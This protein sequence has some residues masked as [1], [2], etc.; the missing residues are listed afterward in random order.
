MAR[1]RTARLLFRSEPQRT[2]S[3]SRRDRSIRV[4]SAPTT[5]CGAGDEA[6]KVSWVTK[7]ASTISFRCWSTPSVGQPSPQA[8]STPVG[9]GR[10][11][12]CGAGRE[13]C[14]SARRRFRD[15]SRH[16][17][18]SRYGNKLDVGGNRTR[19]QLRDSHK[20]HAV[21]LGHERR[22]AA[23]TAP[24]TVG[25][26]LRRPVP[27][28]TGRPLLPEQRVGH[29]CA[30]HRWHA[31]VLWRQHRRPS[32]RRDLRR[33]AHARAGRNADSLAVC[34]CRGRTHARHF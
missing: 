23:G 25:P 3:R 30:S 8:L 21:V 17:R 12:R 27:R 24:P 6:S 26:C 2:G 13:R 31:V 9:F 16:T 11:G 10:T 14:R 29:V 5:R 4:Q 34:Q 22:R 7:P 19:S 15:R 18:A 20:R 28:R 33:T 32:R 1:H